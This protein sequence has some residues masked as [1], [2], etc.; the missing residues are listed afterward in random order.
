M[1]MKKLIL[2]ISAVLLAS[3]ACSFMPNIFQPGNVEPTPT[4]L[5]QD[6]FSNPDSGWPVTSESDKIAKYF[7]GQYDII[8]SKPKRDVWATI[9][10]QF[11]GDIR[12]EVDATKAGGPDDNDFG[13]VCHFLD[14]NN[15][16]YFLISSDGYQVIGRYLKGESTFLSSDKMQLS[17]AV[18][19]GSTTNQ[20]RADCIGETLL[21][22]VNNQMVASTTDTALTGGTVG[23][24]VGTFD[25]GGV[26]ILFDNFVVYQP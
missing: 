21:L 25:E 13:L 17:D 2:L 20:I 23:M 14:D 4:I 19:K 8:V 10:Q 15:F 9:K 16:H 11:A 22:Y 3:L 26:D 5:Y 6:N 12:V 24:I 1:I 7:N 18:R